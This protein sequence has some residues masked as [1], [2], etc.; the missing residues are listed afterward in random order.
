MSIRRQAW[1]GAVALAVLLPAAAGAQPRNPFADLFGRAPKKGV[2]ST[3]VYLRTTAGAQIGQTVRA[4]F[5]QS[6]V[7]PEGLAGGADASV[8]AEH[9]RDRFQ[10]IGQGRYSYQEYRQTQ[11]FGAPAFDGGARVN[12]QA[13]SRL[14][15]QGGGQFLRSPYFRMMWLTPEFGPSPA[16][17]GAAIL[18]MRNDSIE[19]NAGLIA[20]VTRRSNLT[21]SAFVRETSFDRQ[22]EYD[23]SSR[24]ARALWRRQL[25]RSF[26]LRLGYGRDEL[27]QI[28][29]GVNDSYTNELLDVGVDFQCS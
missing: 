29:D 20:Q 7:V 25:N 5:D 18:L 2:E 4:D 15:F 21:A 10:V 9:I 19:A 14:S 17:D 13:T 22:P 26:G 3:S 27:R 28:V 6:D 24:G 16:G 12:V 23:F 8:A 1:L 11:A